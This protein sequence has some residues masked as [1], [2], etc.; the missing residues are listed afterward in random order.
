MAVVRLDALAF[1]G[2]FVLLPSLSVK[3]VHLLIGDF[4]CCRYKEAFVHS[5]RST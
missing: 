3:T 2:D 1:G 5:H 4:L